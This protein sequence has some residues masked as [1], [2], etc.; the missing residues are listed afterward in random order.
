MQINF[1][2][3]K[4]EKIGDL[5]NHNGYDEYI[6]TFKK[7]LK[8]HQLRIVVNGFLTNKTINLINGNSGYKN[9]ILSAISDFK[10]NNIDKNNVITKCIT[11]GFLNSVYN[12]KIITNVQNYLMNIN[13]EESRDKLT[14]FNLI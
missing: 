8:V 7:G 10:N 9:Q 12:K 5:F 13:K 4:Y 6:I 11:L 3:A 2:I 14:E 1:K